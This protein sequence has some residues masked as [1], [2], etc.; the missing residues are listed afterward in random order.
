MP[1]TDS[2][3]SRIV[4][5]LT[6]QLAD[7]L[8]T[9][10]L[11]Y[12]ATPDF[13][14][15]VFQAR[16][17]PVLHEAARTHLREGLR[18]AGVP[19]VSVADTIHRRLITYTDPVDFSA[20]LGFL[21][22][23]ANRAGLVLQRLTSLAE[24]HHFTTRL[25]RQIVALH[26][27]IRLP[28]ADVGRAVPCDLLYVEPEIDSSELGTPRGR[29]VIL[30]DPGSGKSTFAA[31][32]AHD[33]AS[34]AS[35]RVPF[36][37]VLRDF[38]KPLA[39]Y[40][41]IPHCL[42]SMCRAP[43]DVDPPPDAV[44]YLLATNRAVV[45]L[46]GLD[47]LTDLTLRRRVVMQ[48]ESF[49]RQ[50]PLV[51]IV[52]TTRGHGY[53]ESPLNAETFRQVTLPAF[54]EHQVKAYAQRWY[55][56][57]ES[58]PRSEQFRLTS[59]FLEDSR[60]VPELRSNPLLLSLLCA[61]SSSDRYLARNL[62]LVYERCAV[63]LFERWD[64][65]RGI[66]TPFKF[67]RRV[68]RVLADL[69]WQ[70]LSAPV[71]G[72]LLSHTR[73]TAF[74]TDHAAMSS[75]DHDELV[76]ATTALLDHCTGRA[77]LMTDFGSTD[78]EPLLGFTHRAFLE[79]LAASHVLRTHDSAAEIWAAL[80]PNVD[81]WGAMPQ[82]ALQL[83]DRSFANGID[84]LLQLAN[85][86]YADMFAAKALSHAHLRPAL[87]ETITH[88]CAGRALAVDPDERVS[89]FPTGELPANDEPLLICL[90]DSLAG[91]VPIVLNALTE[92]ME[93]LP[94]GQ[95]RAAQ[96]VRGVLS[97]PW[98]DRAAL[99]RLERLSRLASRLEMAQER[100]PHAYFEFWSCLGQSVPS[101]VMEEMYDSSNLPSDKPWI[102]GERWL[103]DYE[104]A[105]H[106]LPATRLGPGLSLPY[107]EMHVEH[108]HPLPFE[109]TQVH[110]ALLDARRRAEATGSDDLL[111]AW[112]SNRFNVFSWQEKA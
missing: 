109:P 6:G 18:L 99:A 110:V 78:T 7:D 62:A 32:L 2:A 104:R 59:S 72:S 94:S 60:H 64:A 23:A 67:D 69:A 16:T 1:S 25:R 79:L 80:R 82:I 3:V 33:V 42:E 58:N 56:L 21:L 101:L 76:M 24:I 65:L 17:H 107:L 92:F 48:L 68:R 89:F 95:L 83:F 12:L 51:P 93:Q 20:D 49:A 86:D 19:D 85:R 66:A 35:G 54:T 103:R 10:A 4:A 27:E 34:E 30:G 84:S 96:L 50:H 40:S 36:L 46:D 15:V 108:G 63:L 14:A 11:D 75:D 5:E 57:D 52:V 91:N 106:P 98:P 22:A 87:T 55:A 44:D 43:Y 8:G 74:L 53:Q 77:W 111:R 28:H 9:A 29:T 88:L 38:Q 26:S 97:L 61:M 90:R 112:T 45:V 13:A 31:K 73:I 71:S 37:I 47:E 39:D 105:R 102:S 100:G 70:M 41:G 81:G